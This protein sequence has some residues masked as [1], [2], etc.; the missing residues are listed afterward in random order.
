MSQA[1]LRPLGFGEILDGAF[2]LYRRHFVS[3]FVTALVP[4]VPIAILSAEYTR[5][6]VGFEAAPEA[7]LSGFPFGWLFAFVIVASLGFLIVW[8][9]LTREISAAVTGGE[10]STEDGYGTALRTLLPLLGAGLLAWGIMMAAMMVA[11]VPVGIVA[12]LVVGGGGAA[13]ALFGFIGVLVFFVLVTLLTVSLFAVVPVVVIEKV[14]PWTALKRSWQLSRGGRWRILGVVLVSYLITALP[15]LGV[16]IAAGTAG[17]MYSP[18][19]AAG[20]SPGQLVFQQVASTLSG[21]LT[22]PFFIGCLVLLYYDRRVRTEGYD[23][24]LAAEG[25]AVAG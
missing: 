6:M 5:R 24:E 12:A 13:A 7:G 23:V 1:D 4:F 2:T 16:T 18:A 14:G 8:G 9:A 3:F 15:V 22:L 21:A 25:L 19:A 11:M 10:V 20:L 17:A